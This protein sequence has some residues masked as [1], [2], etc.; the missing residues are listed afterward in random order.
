MVARSRPSRGKLGSTSARVPRARALRDR[1]A[2]H[3]PT[4]PLRE[5]PGQIRRARAKVADAPEALRHLAD[6]LEGAIHEFSADAAPHCLESASVEI[7]A[8]AAAVGA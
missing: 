4:E 7:L 8:S 1:P 3:A 2:L 6:I 5:V